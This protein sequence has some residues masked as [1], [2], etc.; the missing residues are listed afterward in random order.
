MAHPSSGTEHIVTRPPLCAAAPLME[1]LLPLIVGILCAEWEGATASFLLIAGGGGILLYGSVR[2]RAVPVLWALI[3]LAIGFASARNQQAPVYEDGTWR[4]PR[5][6]TLT[7]RLTRLFNANK[8][9]HFA[10]LATIVEASSIPD[11]PPGARIAVY[12]DAA[13]IKAERILPGAVITCRGVLR[14][15]QAEPEPDDYESYLIRQNVFLSLNQGN[16]TEVIRPPP[17]Q[18]IARHA[19][20]EKQVALLTCACKEPTD[21]G[22]VIGSM[23]LGKRSLLSKERVELYRLSGTFHLFAVSGLHVGSICAT[24]LAITGFMRFP[25]ILR[26]VAILAG[27][28]GYVWMTGATPSGMRAGIMLSTVLCARNIL[29]QPH[30]FP[31]LVLSATL[32]LAWQPDQLFHLGFQ[33]SYSVVMG[34]VLIGLPLA[35]AIQGIF[36]PDPHLPPRFRPQ[37]ERRLRKCMQYFT[38]LV[39]IAV[40]SSLVSMP[41]II[42]HFELL[43]PGGILAGMLINTLVAIIVAVAGVAMLVAPIAGELLAGTLVVSLWPLVE[44]IEFVLRNVIA[45]PHAVQ[46]A[47][48]QLPGLGPFTSLTCLSMAWIFQRLRMQFPQLPALVAALPLVFSATM[49]VFATVRT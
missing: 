26:L 49:L 2:Q 32:V 36:L 39:C 11:M 38:S 31:A 18:A 15:L 45:I 24:L 33:L 3:A 16:V 4:P 48:W 10:G 20:L 28:W 27:T 30:I 29:R 44:L 6:A 7:I 25:E 12:L 43:S 13:D 37:T 23:L 9:D 19:L 46:S 40:S 41:L 5:E 34:I 21:P 47:S 22:W 8:P 42:E 35:S 1:V 17:K 14:F